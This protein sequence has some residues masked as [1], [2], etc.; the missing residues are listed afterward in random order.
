MYLYVNNNMQLSVIF[1]REYRYEYFLFTFSIIST[2]QF[3]RSNFFPLEKSSTVV[4]KKQYLM[5]S[6]SLASASNFT[7]S[8]SSSNEAAFFK[9]NV[10]VQTYKET[11]RQK[12][13]R[14]S[15]SYLSQFHIVDTHCIPNFYLNSAC[16]DFVVMYAYIYNLEDKSY[17][18]PKL[19]VNKTKRN[20][21]VFFTSYLY[22]N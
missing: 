2:L 13:K 1:T 4:S 3:D 16:L 8:L 11:K 18:P 14:V 10:N 22:L 9:T 21:L 12:R 15:C 5:R 17:L 6:L 20:L 7:G 19:Y